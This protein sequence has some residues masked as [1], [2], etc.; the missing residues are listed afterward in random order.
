M[1]RQRHLPADQYERR[2]T[3]HR[4]L[5]RTLDKRNDALVMLQRLLLLDQIDLVLEDDDVLELHDFNCSQMFARLWLR[6][7]FVT[8]NEEKSCVH[9]SSTV[10]HRSHE[11]V[12]SRTIDERDMANELHAGVTARALAWG[13]VFLV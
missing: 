10:K 8:S 3:E 11:N 7:G 9:D 6:A 4:T 2:T 5:R 13:V 12:V 1:I